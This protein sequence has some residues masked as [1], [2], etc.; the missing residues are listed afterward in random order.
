MLLIF[1]PPTLAVC[2]RHDWVLPPL[3]DLSSPRLDRV[4]TNATADLS[5]LCEFSTKF[6][7]NKET[8]LKH[9]GLVMIVA[10]QKMVWGHKIFTKI[11]EGPDCK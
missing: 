11:S 8:V 9:A 6:I 3:S 10:S 4:S 2:F 1:Y 5:Q 7:C